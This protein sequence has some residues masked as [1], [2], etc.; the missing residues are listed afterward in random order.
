MKPLNITITKAAVKSEICPNCEA[1]PFFTKDWN[2]IKVNEKLMYCK[3]DFC[4]RAFKFKRRP[5]SH[6]RDSCG[7]EYII[8]YGE[9]KLFGVRGY[10]IEINTYNKISDQ[11]H[12]LKTY[13]RSGFCEIDD[14][15]KE[16]LNDNKEGIFKVLSPVFSDEKYYKDEKVINNWHY[17][18]TDECFLDDDDLLALFDNM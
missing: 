15:F 8:S 4:N 1:V 16:I 6:Y 18:E 2:I 5:L 12:A 13:F 9:G 3:C 11:F 10:S 7:W 14:I 17:D